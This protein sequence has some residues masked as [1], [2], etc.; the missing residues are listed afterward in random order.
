MS[1]Y[2]IDFML[3]PEPCVRQADHGLR[4]KIGA[5]V[6]VSDIFTPDKMLKCQHFIDSAQHKLLLEAE[7]QVASLG[8]EYMKA[9]A[10]PAYAAAAVKNGRELSFHIKKRMEALNFDFG[11]KAAQSLYDY[12]QDMPFYHSD[13]LPVLFKYIA[14]LHIAIHEQ[15]TGGKEIRRED[16]LADLKRV[17]KQG[18]GG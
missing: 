11:F 12:I 13:A 4:R 10:D 9:A 3:P 8:D 1:S 5:H 17:I 7:T 18:E 14:L 16:M 2:T 6:A 15:M